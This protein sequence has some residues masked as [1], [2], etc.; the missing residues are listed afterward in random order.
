MT[1][2]TPVALDRCEPIKSKEVPRIG[3]QLAP[4]IGQVHGPDGLSFEVLHCD[5]AR[6]SIFSELPLQ[7]P[8]YVRSRMAHDMS[9]GLQ[10]AWLRVAAGRKATGLRRPSWVVVRV[11]S[12]RDCPLR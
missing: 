7:C 6:S 12:G 9:G 3:A 10:A 11:A 1:T 2:A 4:A 8:Y 5:L